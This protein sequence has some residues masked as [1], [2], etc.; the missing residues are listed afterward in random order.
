MIQT[1]QA[2]YPVIGANVDIAVRGPGARVGE[3]TARQAADRR[4]SAGDLV[5]EIDGQTV[6]SADAH[7]P[8]P[9]PPTRREGL[10]D[11]ER[12][13]KDRQATVTLGQQTG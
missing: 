5:T 8:D 9:H 2:V 11:Y 12:D 3:R 4:P 7:R 1:G 10:A 6:T 13:G